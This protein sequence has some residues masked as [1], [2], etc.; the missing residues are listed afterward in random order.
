MRRIWMATLV[1]WMAVATPA[2]ANDLKKIWGGGPQNVSAYSGVYVPLLI[3]ILNRQRLTGYQWGG[4]SAGTLQN[5]K[6]VHDHP[7]HVALAQHDLLD[8][9]KDEYKFTV[10]K[11]DVGPECLYM[12]T[13]QP[14]YDNWGHVVG[15][16]WNIKVA[17][18]GQQSGSWG[19]W[20]RLVSTYNELNDAEVI[21]MSN[22]GEIVREVEAGKATFGFFVMRPDPNSKVFND[23]KEAGLKIVP[24]VDFDLEDLGYQYLSLKVAYGGLFS[25][26]DIITTACTSVAV[27]TGHADNIA[28][29]SDRRVRKRV[30]ATIQRLQAVPDDRFKPKSESW[31]DMFDNIKLATPDVINALKAKA[32]QTMASLSQ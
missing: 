4:T 10:V 25:Q 13:K 28:A 29:S 17:T 24:V 11:P 21:H 7:T 27:I 2:I 22:T 8:Q 26:P 32:K 1:C 16:G 9:L 5:V 14:A 3:D 18:G 6:M 20:Q 30:T 23:I 12:I 19:T 31:R 15:N